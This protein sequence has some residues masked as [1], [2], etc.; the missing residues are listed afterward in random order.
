MKWHREFQLKSKKDQCE[1]V[2]LQRKSIENCMKRLK[3]VE[4]LSEE[5]KKHKG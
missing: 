3:E 1:F 2:D 4:V 5:D